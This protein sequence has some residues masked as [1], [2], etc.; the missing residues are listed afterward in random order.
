MINLR[1][2]HIGISTIFRLRAIGL[3]C[4]FAIILLLTSGCVSAPDQCD[5]NIRRVVS[6]SFDGPSVIDKTNPSAAAFYDITT[7]VE[8]ENVDE[9]ATMCFLVREE[10]SISISLDPLGIDDVLDAGLLGFPPGISSMTAEG[11]MGLEHEDGTDICGVGI[12]PGDFQRR[13]CSGESTAEIYI[14]PFG[15]DGP[16]SAVRK[17]RLISPGGSDPA[18]PCPQGQKC[19]GPIFQGLCSGVCVPQEDPCPEG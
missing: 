2:Q 14:Q 18:V 11:S 1:L 8:K 5:V 19:C 17:V 6:M 3:L 10:D 15:P 12:L 4:T 7:T 9:R 16:N 13:G